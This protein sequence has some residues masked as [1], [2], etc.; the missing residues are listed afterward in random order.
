[1][2]FGRTSRHLLVDSEVED[3]SLLTWQII[4]IQK[5]SV[6]KGVLSNFA[7]FTRNTC[8]GVIKF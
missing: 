5:Q 1:M 4:M 8:I 7:N 6:K 3:T 2:H